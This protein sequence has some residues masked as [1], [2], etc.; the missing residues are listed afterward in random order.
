MEPSTQKSTMAKK[1]TKKVTKQ[2][3]PE[4]EAKQVARPFSAGQPELNGPGQRWLPAVGTPEAALRPGSPRVKV[5]FVLPEPAAERVSLSG[6]FNGWSPDR[7]P[8]K[9]QENGHWAATVELAPGR[10][11]YKYVRDGEW[12]PDPLA[13]EHVWNRYGTLNS[14]LEVR[15]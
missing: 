1:T 3:A 12:I 2:L 5:P 9:R 8:M 15:G 7:H 14:V 4:A 11:E 13:Q 10:Y 6:E